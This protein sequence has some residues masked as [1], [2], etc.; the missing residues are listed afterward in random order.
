MMNRSASR[1]IRDL[2]T[3]SCPTCRC[4]TLD[5]RGQ[6]P[7]C[8]TVLDPK[9]TGSREHIRIDHETGLIHGLPDGP[10]PLNGPT[11]GSEY[12]ALKKKEVEHKQ[13]MHLLKRQMLSTYQCTQ[14]KRKFSGKLA[15]VKWRTTEGVNMETLV[16]PDQRCDG[17][18]VMV[19]DALSLTNPPVIQG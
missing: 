2:T 5:F 7:E 13:A 12:E 14:C 15:R 17:P 4:N 11:T 3:Y 9:K 16:C 18:V 8:G 1:P 10:E 6:C 19:A